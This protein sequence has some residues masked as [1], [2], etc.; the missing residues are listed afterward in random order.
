MP[1]S[2][3]FERWHP[4]IASAVPDVLSKYAVEPSASTLLGEPFVLPAQRPASPEIAES[5]TLTTAGVPTPGPSA[6]AGTAGTHASPAAATSTDT[7]FLMTHSS[8]AR[9]P[10]RADLYHA[11]ARCGKVGR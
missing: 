2:E 3:D 1:T 7:T 11:G 9:C 5:P 4:W 8:A 10:P 6:S